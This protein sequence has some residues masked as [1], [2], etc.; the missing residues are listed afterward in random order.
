MIE[1]VKLT[2]LLPLPYDI[3]ILTYPRV[4]EAIPMDSKERIKDWIED[5]AAEFQAQTSGIVQIIDDE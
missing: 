1:A 3:K 5:I 4:W 2:S